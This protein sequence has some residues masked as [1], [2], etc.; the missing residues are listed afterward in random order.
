MIV[1]ITEK[2]CRSICLCRGKRTRT[3]RTHTHQPE[4]PSPAVSVR[5]EAQKKPELPGRVLAKPLGP[6]S[7]CLSLFRSVAASFGATRHTR[8][9][10]TGGGTVHYVTCEPVILRSRGWTSMD[11]CQWPLVVFQ[12]L[13]LHQAERVN[14]VSV[15]VKGH[16]RTT[17]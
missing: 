2:Q 6:R 5:D 1:H 7:C 10:G 12:G 3:F 9:Q 15:E 16:A 4:P 11:P 8:V 13:D 14:A 17:A